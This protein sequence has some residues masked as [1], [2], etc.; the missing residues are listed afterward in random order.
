MIVR[1]ILEASFQKYGLATDCSGIGWLDDLKLEEVLSGMPEEFKG[2]Y[3]IKQYL[4]GPRQHLLKNF[5]S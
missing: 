5:W 3:I 2:S 1:Q 4:A